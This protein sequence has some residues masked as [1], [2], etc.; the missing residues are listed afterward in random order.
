[1]I[2]LAG[3]HATRYI[4]SSAWTRP[5]CPQKRQRTEKTT[6]EGESPSTKDKLSRDEVFRRLRKMNQP[7]TLFGEEEADRVKRML[8]C[9]AEMEVQ[10]VEEYE[11]TG[12]NMLRVIAEEEEAMRKKEAQEAAARERTRGG[13][14]EASPA[15]GP[16]KDKDPVQ[17]AFEKAAQDLKDQRSDE[18][19][20]DDRVLYWMDRWCA[21][22][23]EDLDGRGDA[24]K[25]SSKGQQATNLYKTSM[26][27]FRPLREQ[28]EARTLKQDVLV[29]LL[30]MI[31]AMR[32][33]NYRDAMDAYMKV[34]IGNAPW[35]IGVGQVGVQFNM[36]SRDK[37][38]ATTAGRSSGAH[39][40]SDEATRK[41][42]QAWKRMMSAIQRIR[43]TDPSRAVN[44]GALDDG[45][46]GAKGGGSMKA[47]YEEA[48]VTEREEIER[49]RAKLELGLARGKKQYDKR[50]SIK[51][52]DWD[53]RK[54]RV[55][56]G[57]D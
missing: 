50:E 16:A 36:A 43:P 18:L 10:G 31:Q 47:A 4:V 45:G 17:L 42:L 5:Q 34:C 41:W 27:Y 54:A 28:L 23:K 37:V 14:A 38:K 51:Q 56:R 26:I 13:K 40:M 8:K 21:E 3:A 30:M 48:R 12:K 52:R 11:W 15:P 20:P 39:I 55:L 9:E 22:W 24:D 2:I 35:P 57:D 7:V 49:G 33:R 44:F 32:D 6:V 19:N 53:R 46:W 1:L 29:G 25:E